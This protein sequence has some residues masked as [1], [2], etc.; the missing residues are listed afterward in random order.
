M[1]GV[2]LVLLY[3]GLALA[4]AAIIL[5]S[6]RYAVKRSA[7]IDASAHKLFELASDTARWASLGAASVVESRPDEFVALRLVLG[8]SE[9]VATIELRPEGGK[10][11]VD[12]VVAGRNTI[13]D[14]AVN[15]LSSR[16]Q[17][18]GPKI[19]RALADLAA[20]A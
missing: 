11:V 10:T 16:E 14:K 2:G 13:G 9:S 15:L 19:D 7:M 20:S 3:F 1:I 6:D 12:C 4:A 17:S 18:I 8:S 5:Q